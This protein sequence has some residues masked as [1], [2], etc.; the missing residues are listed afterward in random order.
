MARKLEDARDIVYNIVKTIH[1]AMDNLVKS[2]PVFRSFNPNRM[3]EEI[4]VPW[5]SGA[6]KY[7]EEGNQ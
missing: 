4:E 6:I 1:A 2:H 3:T 7:Y 5:H